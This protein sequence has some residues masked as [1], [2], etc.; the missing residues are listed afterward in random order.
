MRLPGGS[1]TWWS[2]NHRGQ[3]HYARRHPRQNRGE[4]EISG[5]PP[6]T[7][8]T[9]P[10]P[11][12][13]RVRPDT[14][15]PK[16]QGVPF[17]ETQRREREPLKAEAVTTPPRKTH[18]L[19]KSKSPD[20]L[21]LQNEGAVKRYSALDAS[22][23]KL[24]KIKQRFWSHGSVPWRRR[25]SLKL[26]WKELL[27]RPPTTRVTDNVLAS[28]YKPQ[29]LGSE[30]RPPQPCTTC[31]DPG[32][33]EKLVHPPPPNAGKPWAMGECAT[34]AGKMFSQAGQR[35]MSTIITLYFLT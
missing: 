18:L 29:C 6:S 27:Y 21:Q 3:T 35:T 16:I 30:T 20:R 9:P 24:G 34:T 31:Q 11:P 25:R 12:T 8:Q 19:E 15:W 1:W 14:G 7:L 17:L 10:L 13:G 5:V 32:C 33:P 23:L 2:G 4:D 22:V 28:G 26:G